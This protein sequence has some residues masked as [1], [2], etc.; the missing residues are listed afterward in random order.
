MLPLKLKPGTTVKNWTALKGYL[1][2]E[3]T[4]VSVSDKAVEIDT[5]KAKHVQR[6]SRQDFEVTFDNWSAY[7]SA[8]LSRQELTEMTRYSKYTLSI[9]KYLQ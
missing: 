6:V 5:P 9:I 2:D 8:K 4:I 3:F 7:C 1:G